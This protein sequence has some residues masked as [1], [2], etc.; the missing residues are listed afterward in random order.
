MG[1]LKGQS[2]RTDPMHEQTYRYPAEAWTEAEAKAHCRKHGG[3]RFE[4][5]AHR[6]SSG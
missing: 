5:A 6:A 3:R 4:P 1:K 2:G